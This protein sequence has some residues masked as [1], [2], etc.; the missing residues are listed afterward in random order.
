MPTKKKTAAKAV[1]NSP[2][3]AE[4]GRRPDFVIYQSEV[5]GPDKKRLIQLG[6]AWKHFN[7][8]GINIKLDALPIRAFDGQ[9]VAFPA[10]ERT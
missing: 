2:M 1:E 8:N 9:L 10:K 4:E 6:V 7:G 5:L 3:E